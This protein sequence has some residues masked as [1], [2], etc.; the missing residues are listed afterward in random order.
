MQKITCAGQP[1][2]EVYDAR[3]SWI[4]S[5]AIETDALLFI[6]TKNKRAT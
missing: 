3:D 4:A 6:A 1:M 2:F 5:F